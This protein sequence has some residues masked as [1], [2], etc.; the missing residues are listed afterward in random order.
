[1][2]LPSKYLFLNWGKDIGTL[3]LREENVLSITNF[4]WKSFSLS[5]DVIKKH[6][7]NCNCL[8]IS[9]CK[10]LSLGETPHIEYFAKCI[11]LK[12]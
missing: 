4:L 3:K 5:I 11:R 10:K 12:T 8:K 2:F 1:M 9:S 7:E 6:I